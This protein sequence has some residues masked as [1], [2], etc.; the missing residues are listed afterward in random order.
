LQIAAFFYGFFVTPMFFLGALFAGLWICAIVVG[1]KGEAARAAFV[2][3]A[4]S[5]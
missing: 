2:S 3:G 1:R 5:Q 4:G